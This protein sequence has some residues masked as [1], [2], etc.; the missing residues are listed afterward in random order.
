MK[1]TTGANPNVVYR[2]NGS[3][4][5]DFANQPVWR[6]SVALLCGMGSVLLLFWNR[7]ISLAVLGGTASLWFLLIGLDEMLARARLLGLAWEREAPG[8]R[9]PAVGPLRSGNVTS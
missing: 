4:A 7:S 3:P 9:R 1:T 2:N 8:D 5:M 6:V